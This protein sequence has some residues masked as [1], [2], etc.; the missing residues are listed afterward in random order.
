MKIFTTDKVMMNDAQA[1]NIMREARRFI[2]P[3][4][5]I[6]GVLN[7]VIAMEEFA[8]CSKEISKFIRGKGNRENLIEEI[9]DV[10]ICL[11][12]IQDLYSIK[13]EEIDNAIEMKLDR[14]HERNKKEYEHRV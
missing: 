10:L 4:N 6:P 7:C 8:E 1:L 5:N 2:N 13:D 12:E 14:Q 11:K 3:E 9:G